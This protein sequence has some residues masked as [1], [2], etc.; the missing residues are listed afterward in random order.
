MWKP[1]PDSP[2]SKALAAVAVHANGPP[3]DPAF[4][5]TINF[6]PDRISGNTNLLKV[7]ATDMVLRSQFETKTSNGSLSAHEGGDR[8]LWESRMFSGAYDL[9]PAYR[10]P[11][12]G[13]LNHRRKSVG[14]SPRFGSSHF[15][16]AAHVLQRTTF[17]YPDSVFAPEDYGNA[18]NMGLIP[19]C[20]SDH[21]DELDQYI[22]AQVHGPVVLSRDVEALVLDPCY[23]GTFVETNAMTLPVVVEWHSGFRVA[24]ETLRQ[25]PEYRGQRYVDLASKFAVDRWLTP[26]AI[27]QA[28]TSGEH[29][30]D[31]LKRVW[32]YLARFAEND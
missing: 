27:G 10:R 24:I 15:R 22:E 20:D 19:I 11:K 31:D 21:R 13:A 28:A 7:L 2:E 6:H 16:L 23:I 9:A 4:R 1:L 26:D 14:A 17:C 12:Y 25:F 3:I 32:H 18:L 8:W 29:S 30:N 5:V